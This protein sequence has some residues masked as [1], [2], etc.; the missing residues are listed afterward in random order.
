VRKDRL[1]IIILI[2]RRGP[3]SV[4]PAF[5]TLAEMTATPEQGRASPHDWVNPPTLNALYD[6]ARVARKVIAELPEWTEQQQKVLEKLNC[7]IL[8]YELD[9]YR[10]KEDNG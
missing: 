4:T 2:E 7:A 9:D 1:V 10:R 5:Y 6:A 8:L 3:C